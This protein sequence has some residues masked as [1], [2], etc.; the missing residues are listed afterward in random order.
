MEENT[1]NNDKSSIN[2]AKL[3]RRTLIIGSLAGE[4]ILLAIVFYGGLII[5]KSSNK[6]ST[7]NSVTQLNKNS[8]PNQQPTQQLANQS[9]ATG[10]INQ[11]V[12]I[13]PSLNRSFSF[14]IYPANSRDTC[15]YGIRDKQ[16]YGY[17]VSEVLGADTIICSEE[18]GTLSSSFAG[19][20][21]G[22][23]F[24]IN[25]KDGEIKIIDVEKFEA[26]T[27]KYDAS[28]YNFVGANRTL[29]YWMFRKINQGNPVAYILLDKNNNV[30][31]D[32]INFESNDRGALYDEVND[33][34]LFISRTYSG[35]NVSVKF[36]F[37]PMN[38]LSLRNILTTEP[39]EVQGRGCYPEYLISQPGEIILFPGCLT[40]K[41]KYL[42]SDG[43]IHI[44]L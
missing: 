37:L 1:Q 41:N 13:Y 17:D 5:G 12:R 11:M 33:G 28:K 19:W 39:V 16:G 7:C 34:F 9:P 42:G 18:Q 14:Y 29:K 27:Y 2:I 30:V 15:A 31:L 35:E 38:N 22:N 26:E 43:N 21:D 24:L 4:L 23:K 36:D 8:Q 44:R 25:E 6:T 3:S 40:V 10:N 32:N 20:A